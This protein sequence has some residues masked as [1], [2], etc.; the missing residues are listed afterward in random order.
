MP[1][2]RNAKFIT[3]DSVEHTEAECPNA[4]RTAALKAIGEEEAQA[5]AD[6]FGMPILPVP[7]EVALVA[8]IPKADADQASAPEVSDPVEASTVDVVTENSPIEVPATKPE[9]SVKKVKA[10]KA[11][12]APKPVSLP[13]ADTATLFANFKATKMVN[14]FKENVKDHKRFNAV[15][16]TDKFEEALPGFK[17]EKDLKAFVG[18]VLRGTPGYK[19]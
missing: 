1:T 5:G 19:K 16:G 6:E 18:W 9:K 2:R 13:K 7:P 8:P 10:V 11:E 4:K 12:S 3:S 14:P 15:A 17:D